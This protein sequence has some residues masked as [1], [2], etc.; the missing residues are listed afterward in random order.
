MFVYEMEKAGDI[1]FVYGA[2]LYDME[3]GPGSRENAKDSGKNYHHQY[4]RR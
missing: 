3:Y 2:V 1:S 4:G